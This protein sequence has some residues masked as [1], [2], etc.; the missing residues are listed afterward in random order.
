M[1]KLPEKPPARKTFDLLRAACADRFE[2]T[3][4]QTYEQGLLAIQTRS[5]DVC[6]VDYRLGARNGLD[7]LAEG[8]AKFSVL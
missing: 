1:A 3:W 7:L 2:L 8:T 6:L 5:C 4:A